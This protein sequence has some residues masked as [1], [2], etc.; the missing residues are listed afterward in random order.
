MSRKIYLDNGK[1]LTLY[2]MDEWKNMPDAV[3]VCEC[4]KHS[5]TISTA[6]LVAYLTRPERIPLRPRR[7][8]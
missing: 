4:G 8:Q 7:V 3:H 6:W 2:N 1:V 5:Q